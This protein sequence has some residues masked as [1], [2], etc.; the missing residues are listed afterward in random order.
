[1]T[2]RTTSETTISRRRRLAGAALAGAL[3]ALALMLSVARPLPAR[4]DGYLSALD[5]VPLMPGLAEVPDTGVDFE[6]ASGRIVEAEAR[7]TERPG[8]D[9]GAVL[10]FYAAALP[11]LGWHAAAPARYVRAGEMLEIRVAAA[12]G[13]ITVHFK[14]RPQ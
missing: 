5:D 7:G 1:M 2:R 12:R 3:I 9:R 13:R 8:L 10:A 6:A 11:P 4:G 14:L